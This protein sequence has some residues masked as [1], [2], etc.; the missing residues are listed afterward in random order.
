MLLSG[1]ATNQQQGEV[2]AR[3]LFPAQERPDPAPKPAA[4]D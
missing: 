2:E 3:V 4:A 1:R